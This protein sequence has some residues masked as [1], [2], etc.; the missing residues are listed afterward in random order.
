MLVWY[1]M[2]SYGA[3]LMFLKTP[4]EVIS[5]EYTSDYG[6]AMWEYG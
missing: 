5:E 3:S 4:G 2:Q 6:E 1:R